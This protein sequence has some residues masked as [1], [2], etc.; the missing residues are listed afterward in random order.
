MKNRIFNIFDALG[1]RDFGYL[2]ALGLMTYAVVFAAENYFIQ[3]DAFICLRYA[4]NFAMGEGLRWEPGSGEFGITNFLFTL[5]LGILLTLQLPPEIAVSILTWGASFG[6][7]YFLYR[8]AGYFLAS[9]FALIGSALFF[10]IYTISAYV[11]GGLETSL[12]AMW[13]MGAIYYALRLLM[14]EETPYG[15]AI[16]FGLCALALL[17]RLDNLVYLLIPALWVFIFAWREQG[18]LRLMAALLPGTILLLAYALYTLAVYGTP[19]PSTFYA[20]VTGAGF[21]SGLEYLHSFVRLDYSIMLAA[22]I[23]AGVVAF[24]RNSES[25]VRKAVLLT[26]PSALLGVAYV[27]YVGGDFMWYRFLYNP[28][29]LIF[30]A[31]LA[32]IS[33][34][35]ERCQSVLLAIAIVILAPVNRL[36]A[37]DPPSRTGL[38]SPPHLYHWVDRDHGPFNWRSLGELLGERTRPSNQPFPPDPVISTKAAGAI[39]YYSRLSTIDELGLNTRSIAMD[40]PIVSADAGHQK[41]AS[42]EMLVELGV[43]LRLGHPTGVCATNGGLSSR[44]SRELFLPV[45]DD[46]FL[47]MEY[48]NRSP[49]VEKMIAQRLLLSSLLA[50]KEVNLEQLNSVRPTGHSWRRDAFGIPMNQALAINIPARA[51]NKVEISLDADDGYLIELLREEEMAG[52]RYVDGLPAFGQGPA[53]HELVVDGVIDRL[54]VYP[55]TG[56]GNYALGH[57]ALH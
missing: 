22:A 56:D 36:Q 46:C 29:L 12:A 49:R 24:C 55:M 10:S 57:V 54:I 5:L 50:T 33:V 6:V 23:F 43:N 30:A 37:S 44:S 7:G 20:K 25:A 13:V 41:E 17:T 16:F 11:S 2:V 32:A 28:L 8:F 3:D 4:E 48:L 9:H 53:V 40:A 42:L 21:A 18:P 26:L 39:P 31:W 35:K 45:V 15:N 27:V 47:R 14:R 19:M 52:V 34:S 38:E 1:D 51:V